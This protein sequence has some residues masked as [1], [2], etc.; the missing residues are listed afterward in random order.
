MNIQIKLEDYQFFKGENSETL[1][2][3]KHKGFRVFLLP[4]IDIVNT[5]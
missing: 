3:R 5:K 4:A 1:K 2:R